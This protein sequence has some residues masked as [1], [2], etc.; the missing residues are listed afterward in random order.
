MAGYSYKKVAEGEVLSEMDK[1]RIIALFLALADDLKV[2]AESRT[3]PVEVQS[4]TSSS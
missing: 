2:S 3:S 1:Q 4:L